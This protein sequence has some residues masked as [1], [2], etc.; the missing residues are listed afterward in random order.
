[1]LSAILSFTTFL[2]VPLYSAGD[3]PLHARALLAWMRVGWFGV[4]AFLL[5][6]AIVYG[7][8]GFL[9]NA[10]VRISI[11]TRRVRI[12]FSMIVGA[13]ISAMAY[14]LVL[15]LTVPHGAI[16]LRWLAGAFGVGALTALVAAFA[17]THERPRGCPFF[18]SRDGGTVLAALIGAV[19]CTGGF[20]ILMQQIPGPLGVR[21]VVVNLLVGGSLGAGLTIPLRAIEP[22]RLARSFVGA[23]IGVVALTTAFSGHAGGPSLAGLGA[24]AAVG[25]LLTD[26][27]P[28]ARRAKPESPDAADEPDPER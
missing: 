10:Y 14:I 15:W 1:L 28:E 16:K 24:G 11:D 8:I 25:A 22:N 5:L 13:I 26:G 21:G 3:A 18:Q 19:G 20:N 4:A 23:V 17:A 27:P 7:G 12:G 9:V 6:A 2:V